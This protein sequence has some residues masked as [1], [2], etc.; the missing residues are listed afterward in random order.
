MSEQRRRLLQAAGASMVAVGGGGVARA[1]PAQPVPVHDMSAFPPQWTGS[2]QIAMLLYPGFTALDLVGPQYMLASLMGA[3]VHL[4][5]K[6]M[7][8]VLSD[9]QMAIVPT[10]DFEHCPRALDILFVPGGGQGTLD[11]MRDDATVDFI[12][13]R[14]LVAKQ[15]ASV[16]TG[17]LL[18]GQAGLL[19]GYR[20]TSHWATHDLL[21]EFGARP[22]KRRVVVDRNRVTGAGVSAGLDLG[23]ALVQ[24][25]RDRLYAQV[26]QLLAEYAPEPPLNAGSP[27]TAPKRAVDLIGGMF[28]GLRA[29]LKAT[30]ASARR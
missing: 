5:A 8:P 22:V 25:H 23:L 3:E 17:S 12:R 27:R 21:L 1:Q 6:T 16:C 18:L 14:G 24:Q 11:A 13:E 15:L 28:T 30:A 2:E 20:A 19:R 4:V 26:V 9:T 29:E 10:L 7:E